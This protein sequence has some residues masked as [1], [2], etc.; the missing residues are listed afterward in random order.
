MCPRSGDGFPDVLVVSHDPK[1]TSDVFRAFVKGMGSC[2][3]VGSAYH[4]NTNANI[5][6][7]NGVIG[8]TLRAFANGRSDNWDRQPPLAEFA[9]NNAAS[10]L[11]RMVAGASR[12]GSLCSGCGSSSC[13]SAR[14]QTWRPHSVS[15]RRSWTR[16]GLTDTVFKVVGIR[17]YCGPRSCWTRR[18]SASSACD[19]KAPSRSRRA[20]AA[21][22]N[23][24][25]LELP[26][27][28]RCSSTLNVDRLKPF[29]ER[30]G[31]PPAPGPVSDPGHERVHEVELLLNR[32]V[33]GVTNYLVRCRGHFSAEDEW[34]RAADLG[35]CPEKVP[36]R[37]RA[38]RRGQVGSHRDPP[39][40]PPAPRDPVP[41]RAP[42]GFRLAGPG[43]VCDGAALAG[44]QVLYLWP[45]DV[46]LQ[47]APPRV[48]PLSS[49]YRYIGPFDP[50]TTSIQRSLILL[51]L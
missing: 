18:I 10:T 15:A 42:S 11:G 21:G 35:H 30:A 44:S 29:N 31:A 13:R 36:P 39:A 51:S 1:F 34:L 43:E 49:P 27:K 25:M 14:S 5:E 23:A 6:R 19:G 22:P 2:L 8:D 7:A 46:W 9:I 3:I 41:R 38:A 50:G 40:P 12:R 37:R 33:R 47:G 48:C 16:G 17:C 45:V 32:K 26:R 24:D 20:R 28:V 4:K